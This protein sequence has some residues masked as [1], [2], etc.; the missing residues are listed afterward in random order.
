MATN[1]RDDRNVERIRR[2]RAERRRKRKRRKIIRM[3]VIIG[4]MAAMIALVIVGVA[5][6]VKNSKS[7]NS[8]NS[9]S[10]SKKVSGKNLVTQSFELTKEDV[11]NLLAQ[12][13]STNNLTIEAFTKIVE[14]FDTWYYESG[15]PAIEERRAMVLNEK[16]MLHYTDKNTKS[17][18]EQYSATLVIAYLLKHKRDWLKKPEDV[19]YDT[20]IAIGLIK[21]SLTISEKTVLISCFDADIVNS[22]LADEIIRILSRQE[23]KLD[24]NFLL[25]VMKLTNLTGERIRV[26]KY[27]L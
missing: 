27:T 13:V 21:S 25:K 3:C 17:I 16:G 6:G 12:F 19:A 15:V 4:A 10:A 24:V 7:K 26:L 18:I 9:K 14:C 23:I 20:D 22:E 5:L 2:A 11:Q 1:N 8:S